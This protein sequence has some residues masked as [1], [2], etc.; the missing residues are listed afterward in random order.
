MST[1]P[2]GS[3]GG[4]WRIL[5]FPIHARVG[6]VSVVDERA[7]RSGARHYWLSGV[8]RTILSSCML[9]YLLIRATRTA[10]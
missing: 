3:A 8:V 4:E 7:R 2:D 10:P 1:I 6:G 5:E 9:R